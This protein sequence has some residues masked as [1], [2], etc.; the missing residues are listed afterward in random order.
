MCCLFD[1]LNI[2]KNIHFINISIDISMK[3]RSENDILWICLLMSW[4]F[5]KM[6][7]F[8]KPF[9][10][11][12]NSE[13]LHFY[14]SKRQG[15]MVT[16]YCRSRWAHKPSYSPKFRPET[17][18]SSRAWCHFQVIK[19]EAHLWILRI[20]WPLISNL[21]IFITSPFPLLVHF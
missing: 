21:Q 10:F 20:S 18:D 8:H 3:L 1:N 6:N 7:R 4:N 11:T 14:P 19:M 9:T 17:G 5:C 13:F 15:K 12:I 2:L 16:G